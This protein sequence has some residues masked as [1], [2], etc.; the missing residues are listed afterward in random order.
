[1]DPAFQNALCPK[2][3]LVLGLVLRPLTVGHLGVFHRIG[4]DPFAANPTFDQFALCAFICRQPW[5][6]SE[7]DKDRWWFWWFVK[8]WGLRCCKMNLAAETSKF[9]EYLSRNVAAPVVKFQDGKFR[10][11]SSPLYFRLLGQLMSVLH[12]TKAEALDTPVSEA[13]ALVCAAW[14]SEGKIDLWTAEDESFWQFAHRM[15]LER[16][17]QKQKGN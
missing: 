8:L 10:S 2:P 15:D 5:R 13:T 6:I 1:M 11:I 16:L 9:A 14:E 17:K 12:M 7:R 4:Y 3:A